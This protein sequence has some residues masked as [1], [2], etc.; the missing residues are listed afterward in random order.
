LRF[1][2]RVGRS[3]AVVGHISMVGERHAGRILGV[4]GLQI[5]EAELDLAQVKR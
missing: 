5:G 1:G 3:E 4:G 2:S